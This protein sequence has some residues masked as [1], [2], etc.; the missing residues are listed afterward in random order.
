MSNTEH[1]PAG[2]RH[3][4]LEGIRVVDLA[5]EAAALAGRILADLGADVVRVGPPLPRLLVDEAWGV[6]KRR[7]REDELPSLL[8]DA[9]V[10]IATPHTR[11]VAVADRS[12]APKAVWVDVTPF[13]L[14]GPRSGWRASDLGVMASSGNM[15]STG[16]PDRA[17]VRCTEPSGYSH[18][19]PEA[20]F[21][22]LTGLASGRPQHIDLSMQ[23]VVMVASMGAAGR[24]FREPFAG[25]R[26][27]A[28][29][30]RLKEIW[31][32]QDGW[33]S[34]GLRGGKART[35]NLQTI[36]RL[37]GD[38]VLTE[39]DWATYNHNTIP[40]AELVEIESIIGAWFS[41][42][43]M[44][45]LYELACETNLMLAPAN[46]PRE[47]Y[48]SAQL[49]AREF[50][51]ED[52]LPRSFVLARSV[53][54]ERVPHPPAAPREPRSS[55]G[56][57]AGTRIL[58][59]GGGAAGPIATRYYAEH[60]AIVLKV[61][62]RTRPDFLRSMALAANHRH[63]LEGSDMFDALNVGKRTITLN[64]KH[65]DAVA[66]AKR[67]VC[68]WADAVAENYA[69]RAMRGFGLDYD[70]LAAEK[71]DLVMISACLQGNTGPHRNYPGF[72]GQGSAL[73]GF[74]LLTGWPD[75][76]P[77]G[78]YGTI[79]DSLAP[80]FVAAALGAGLLHHRRTGKG[81]YLDLAQVEA[82]AYSLT[83]WLLEYRRN[84]QIVERLGNDDVSG[85]AKMHGAF[86]C[87]G[88][89]RWVVVAAWDDTELAVLE[90]VSGGDLESWASRQSPVS[91]ASALQE[92]GLEAVPVQDFG[93]AFADPQLA[94]REHF[95]TLEHPVLGEGRYERN[96]FRLS[97]APSGY[98]RPSPTLGE[99]NEWAL[100][101]VLGLD[102]A[103][104][105]RLTAIGALD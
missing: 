5:G 32:C 90:Q 79:T 95:V 39:R 24:F 31:R 104:V 80:R 57:W 1:D 72:G 47:L 42:R 38:P 44:S 52:G 40:D 83:P 8:A 12:L 49:S 48:A 46:S 43:T 6:G 3:R 67:L 21:A 56:A 91:A 60:G 74:N 23:E 89:D 100:R 93:D 22:A 101:D 10:V 62:S 85:R 26:Q 11:G 65:P 63:G 76:A 20:A 25:R 54:Q 84:G 55:G 37:I 35:P 51:D 102:G 98:D 7:A 94:F 64:L 36:S 78:P 59:F 15:Y 70:T 92:G 105:E 30:G 61:E 97:D 19:G 99:D 87:A 27:G 33:V 41:E 68:E 69:P 18:V 71:P 50:F 45:E 75:R 77:V 82:A 88:E 13:G 4:L 53:A 86:P 14:E 34:F 2:H 81:V 58:E 9:D 103:E 66:L 29:M 17:P 28:Q 96:G 16:D 73:S